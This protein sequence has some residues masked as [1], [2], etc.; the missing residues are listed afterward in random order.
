MRNFSSLLDDILPKQLKEYFPKMDRGRKI[1]PRIDRKAGDVSTTRAAYK[2]GDFIGK[3]YEVFG[4]LGVG[5]FSVV[6]LV[7][8]HETESAYALKTLRDQFLEDRETR[9]QFR[10]EAKLW[11]DLERHPYLV[12]ANFIDE[13]GGR[14][15]IGM[16]YI[17]PNEDGLNSLEG[18]LTHRPPDLLQ[19]FRWAIQF[20]HGMEYA[21]AKGIRCHRDVKPANIMITADRIVKI[22]DFGFAEV[23]DVTRAKHGMDLLS[24]R[25]RHMN[26][27][28][29]FGTPTYMPPEQFQNAARC[30]ERSDIYSFGVVLYQMAS[31]GKL[32]FE[33]NLGHKGIGSDPVAVWR[34]MHRMHT[35]AVVAPLQSPLLPVIQR[36]L[37]K[38]PSGRYQSF[39]ELRQALDVLMKRYTGETV[40]PQ[41]TKELEAWELY[42]KAFSLSS[43]GHT[44]EAIE[45]YGKVLDLEPGNSDAWNNMGVCYRKLGRLDNALACYDKAIHVQRY[46]ASSW[47]NRGNILYTMGRFPESIVSL[48]KA[49]EI[50][51]LNESAWLN[52]ALVEERLGLKGEAAISFQTFIDLK[53]VEYSAHLAYAQKRLADLKARRARQQRRNPGT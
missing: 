30:D 13:L 20:C 53:P 50:D 31:R 4:V 35:E 34:E 24:R 21:R 37:Q 44:E 9:D 7:Y 29:G 46:N 40:V 36:C 33:P 32:P 1:A 6:Y 22:T 5:G 28:T 12:S 39:K 16:E 45:C 18:Y 51:P 42:N 49:I 2:K 48:N 8:S 25:R 41:Q 43:L 23:I 26:D 38:E 3:A 14:L 10:K 11:V 47:S 19:T 52:K 17:A 27:P 15:Y